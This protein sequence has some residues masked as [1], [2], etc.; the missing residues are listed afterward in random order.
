VCASDRGAAACE[1]L[2]A[3]PLPARRE[4]PGFAG[5]WRRYLGFATPTRQPV[6]VGEVIG[7]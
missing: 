1:H 3:A 2:I 5:I 4:N 7:G 6:A